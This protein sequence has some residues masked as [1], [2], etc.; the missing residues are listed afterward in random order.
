MT[1]A[2]IQDK[3]DASYTKASFDLDHLFI[4]VGA[5]EDTDENLGTFSGSTI[6]DNQT[7][8]ASI[9]ELETAVETKGV[10]DITGVAAGVGLS[11]GG[12]SGDVT[13][14]MDISEFSDVTP[15]NGDKLLTLDSDGSTEQ[16]TTVASLAT[17][18]REQV[19]QQQILY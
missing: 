7:I 13:L 17:L 19:S 6:S 3:I 14:T 15:A 5:P 9:Q 8:K 2:A 16:L 11:G 4:L 10:G 1:S 18:S 12:T